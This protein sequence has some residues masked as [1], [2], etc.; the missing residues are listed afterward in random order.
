MQYDAL[1]TTSTVSKLSGYGEGSVRK[2]ADD[3]TLAVAVR[4]STG[5][6]LFHPVDVLVFSVNRRFGLT[7]KAIDADTPHAVA[8]AIIKTNRQSVADGFGLLEA[9]SPLLD[10]AGRLAV[11]GAIAKHLIPVQLL[12]GDAGRPVDI[13]KRRKD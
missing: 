1:L 2:F 5:E 11:S 4:T 13:I 10:D 3:G 9:L 7:L 8:D 6:R 12:P